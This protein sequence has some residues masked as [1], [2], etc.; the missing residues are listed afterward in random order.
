MET[1]RPAEPSGVVLKPPTP[2]TDPNFRY[3]PS[4]L[5]DIRKRFNEERARLEKK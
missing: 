2:I 1:L 4:H 5:T 3:T